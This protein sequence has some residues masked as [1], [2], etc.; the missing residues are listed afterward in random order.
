MQDQA[1]RQLG[2][3]RDE[4]AKLH[5]Y[6]IEEKE[7][8][9]VTK[10]HIQKILETG[11]DSFETLHRTKLGAIKNVHVLAKVIEVNGHK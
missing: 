6:E 1:C 4:F 10:D 5:L 11:F 8:V 2:Y 7:T 3:S 9:E